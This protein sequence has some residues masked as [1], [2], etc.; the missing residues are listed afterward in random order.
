MSE[1]P[2]RTYASLADIRA[3]I[4]TID[5]TLVATL[6]RRAEIVRAAAAFKKDEQAVRAPDRVE[7]VVQHARALALAENADPDLIERIYRHLIAAMTEAELAAHRLARE[8]RP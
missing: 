6:A 1:M 2:P 3:A 7:A 8:S 4:D 5:A